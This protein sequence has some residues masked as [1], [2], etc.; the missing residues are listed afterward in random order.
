MLERFSDPGRQVM[1]QAL[2][3]AQALGHPQLAPEHVLLALFDGGDDPAAALRKVRLSAK[4]VRESIVAIV[5]SQEPL[6]ADEMLPLSDRAQD[7]VRWAVDLADAVDSR[8]VTPAQ[9]LLAVILDNDGT[10]IRILHQRSVDPFELEWAILDRLAPDRQSDLATGYHRAANRIRMDVEARSPRV[11]DP[12]EELCDISDGLG[13]TELRLL[14]RLTDKFRVSRAVVD[15]D[16]ASYSRLVRMVQPFA[17]RYPVVEGRGNFGSIDAD[18]P[19]D[20]QYTEVR[21]A[22]LA[23]D[24]RSFPYLLANGGPGIPPHNLAEVI[25]ATL[26]YLDDPT[27]DTTGLLEHLRGPDFPTAGTVINGHDLHEIYDTG[28][29]SIQIQGQI[30]VE[31]AARSTDLVITQLP[32][33]AHKGGDGGLITQIV[34]LVQDRT[35]AGISDITDQSNDLGMRLIVTIRSEADPDAVVRTL[36]ERT[37]LQLAVP[38]DMVALV[39]GTARRLSLHGLISEWVTAR[40]RDHSDD[41][42]GTQLQ[43]VADRHSSTRLTAIT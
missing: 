23:A 17:T 26:A 12:L 37:M 40:R 34:D 29:G 2:S 5:G 41:D 18:P 21:V 15:G 33:G 8:E 11:G 10:A 42:I 13:D 9:L 6:P 1:A 16:R 25:A 20:M 30:A 31:P 7:V 14:A 24:I 4:R 28:A 39:D 35:L 22:Q 36:H 38:V 3:E 32:F 43:A 19:A 27:L